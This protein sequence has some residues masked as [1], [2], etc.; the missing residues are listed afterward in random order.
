MSA[1]SPLYGPWPTEDPTTLNAKLINDTKA[2]LAVRVAG[3]S[4]A[5]VVFVKWSDDLIWEQIEEINIDPADLLGRI[6][7]LFANAAPTY[8]HLWVKSGAANAVSA[9]IR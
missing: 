1:I 4:P 2:E 8:Y 9:W 3:Q 7:K 6:T 5:T